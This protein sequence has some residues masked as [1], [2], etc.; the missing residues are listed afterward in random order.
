MLV[1][2]GQISATVGQ[3]W[4][5]SVNLWPKS[6]IGPIYC[7]LGASVRRLLDNVGVTLGNRGDIVWQLLDSFGA[8]LDC[9]G[10]AA[11]NFSAQLFVISLSL[12]PASAGPPAHPQEVVH[13][14]SSTASTCASRAS[15]NSNSG[16][17]TSNAR[18]PVARV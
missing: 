13:L 16:D 6:E 15:S 2:V 17:S 11:S 9:W 4:P 8:V 3:I 18:S 5:T 7:F 14:A 1:E 10:Y 12:E